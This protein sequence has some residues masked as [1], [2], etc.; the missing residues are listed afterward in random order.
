MLESQLTSVLSKEWRMVV[1]SVQKEKGADI[2]IYTQ[3][4]DARGEGVRER[5]PLGR[6][7]TAAGTEGG[8]E[9][10][11]HIEQHKQIM[12]CDRA[13]TPHEYIPIATMHLERVCRSRGD[14]ACCLVSGLATAKATGVGCSGVQVRYEG[15]GGV[16]GQTERRRERERERGV[17]AHWEDP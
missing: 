12:M 9:G 13:G 2:K 10:R 17:Q 6:S 5:R 1:E 14:S 8:S 11:D 4:E 16:G 3:S 7:R 15:G